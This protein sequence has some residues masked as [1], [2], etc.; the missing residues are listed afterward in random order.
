MVEY[1][2]DGIE[3]VYVGIFDTYSFNLLFPVIY[4]QLTTSN[5][6]LKFN[7]IFIWFLYKSS[8]LQT[9]LNNMKHI[10]I[11]SELNK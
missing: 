8:N 5:P 11:H 10:L 2:V 7:E 9:L 1:D 4:Y 3:G 6:F